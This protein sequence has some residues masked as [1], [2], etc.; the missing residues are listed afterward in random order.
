MDSELYNCICMGK[1]SS[2]NDFENKYQEFID[3]ANESN[4]ALL[5]AIGAYRKKFFDLDRKNIPGKKS[6]REFIDDK[7]KT[8]LETYM[9]FMG[10]L[11]DD[12]VRNRE[13]IIKNSPSLS[14]VILEYRKY[15]KV[16]IKEQKVISFKE[17]NEA[18]NSNLKFS[19]KARMNKE[20]LLEIVKKT[21]DEKVGDNIVVIGSND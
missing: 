6:L 16:T 1:D 9:E 19:G 5:G 18:V 12:P 10:C 11:N 13:F 2:I 21:L 7:D 4:K 15:V 17:L 3:E 20:E 8:L 14:E